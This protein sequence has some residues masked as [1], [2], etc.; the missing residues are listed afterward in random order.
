VEVRE[1]ERQ[2]QAVRGL[3]ELRGEKC[4]HREARVLAC[5]VPSAAEIDGR[6]TWYRP[7]C[8]DRWCGACQ[9]ARAARLVPRIAEQLRLRL[10]ARAELALLTVTR[11]KRPEETEGEAVAATLA[12]WRALVGSEIW[13]RRVT[14]GVRAL[15]CTWRG[16]GERVDARGRRRH[17]VVKVSGAHA[18]VHAVIE[19]RL[20]VLEAARTLTDLRDERGRRGV[21]GRARAQLWGE[22]REAWLERSVGAVGAAQ[23][24]R[25]I[26]GAEASKEARERLAD[27]CAAELAAY[28][29]DGLSD[30]HRSVAQ[31]PERAPS[32]VRLL[33][34]LD[35]R[36]TLEALGTWRGVLRFDERSESGESAPPSF[37]ANSLIAAISGARVRWADGRSIPPLEAL[38]RIRAEGPRGLGSVRRLT[39]GPTL[40]PTDNAGELA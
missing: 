40:A 2:R 33:S 31:A 28:V 19:A 4:D 27:S 35:G 13:R 16:S 25:W 36:R 38:A 9:T 1:R 5:G 15:E 11:A 34:A 29:C 8:R 18:H 24:L 20:P 32:Y 3:L 14:G 37:A 23:D 21:A 10:E 26:G 22:L 17:H 39:Q 12:S 30:V 6:L 7:S